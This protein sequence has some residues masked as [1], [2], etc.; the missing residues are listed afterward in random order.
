MSV[1]KPTNPEVY[2][3]II[4]EEYIL[5]DRDY[6]LIKSIQDL[7]KAIEKLRLNLNG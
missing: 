2:P 4:K 6:L 1:N 5:E 7:T 3:T